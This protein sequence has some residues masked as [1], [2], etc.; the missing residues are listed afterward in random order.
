MG[1]TMRV[2]AQRSMIVMAEELGRRVGAGRLMT[3]ARVLDADWG[4]PM[5]FRPEDVANDR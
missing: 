2:D 4:P 3:A 5:A 1:E